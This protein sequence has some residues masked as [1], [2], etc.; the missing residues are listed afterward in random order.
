MKPQAEE[1]DPEVVKAAFRR[2][3]KG[4]AIPKRPQPREGNEPP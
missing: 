2:F 1:S 4:I 3:L